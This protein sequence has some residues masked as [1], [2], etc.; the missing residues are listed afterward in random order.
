MTKVCVSR[1]TS[2]ISGLPKVLRLVTFADIIVR[3]L[4]FSEPLGGL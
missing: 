4:T 3:N 2:I 1:D